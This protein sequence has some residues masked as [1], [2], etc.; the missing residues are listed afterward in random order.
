MYGLERIL[1]KTKG[2]YPGTVRGLKRIVPKNGMKIF[3]HPI[4]F[5]S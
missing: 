2:K 4:L 1:P 3:R 5:L